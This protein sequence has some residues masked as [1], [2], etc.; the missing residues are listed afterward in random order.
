MPS[1]P[2]TVAL[3][4]LGVSYRLHQHAAPVRSLAEAARERGLLPQQIV[5][6]LL[7]RLE[8]ERFVLLL[9]AGPARARWSSL[10]QHLGAS[11]LTTA[12][13]DQVREVT[14]YEP[15]AVSPYGL[16]RPLR[17]LADRELQAH[18]VLSIGAGIRDA[19][20][21]LARQDLERTLSIEYEDFALA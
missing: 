21:I 16:R 18:E 17:I 5:R 15:G 7:F 10:R 6:S 19:G 13:P 2:V 8:G 1:T 9:I 14:G 11:R 20:V 4:A 12:T 3:D